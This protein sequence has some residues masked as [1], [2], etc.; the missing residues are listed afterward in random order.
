MADMGILVEYGIPLRPIIACIREF[1]ENA[2]IDS[3]IMV[4]VSPRP[5]WIGTVTN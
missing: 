5:K 2:P 3:D 1:E 4:I